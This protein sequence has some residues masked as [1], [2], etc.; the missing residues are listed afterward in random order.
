MHLRNACIGATLV[1]FLIFSPCHAFST[2]AVEAVINGM[3]AAPTPPGLLHNSDRLT[4][5]A[6]DHGSCFGI[7]DVVI[8]T[9]TGQ[10]LSA[11]C[12]NGSWELRHPASE[13]NSRISQ[14]TNSGSIAVR[15]LSNATDVAQGR[16]ISIDP[17]DLIHTIPT[18]RPGDYVTLNSG[19]LSGANIQFPASLGS[20]DGPPITIDASDRVIVNNDT[21]ILVSG[22]NISL[23]HFIFSDVADNAITVTGSK[24]SL[25][26][27]KFTKCGDPQKTQSHCIALTDGASKADI[28]FNEFIGSQ[29]MTI[30][31]RE[32]AVGE[33]QPVNI[34]I[35]YN[36]F[37]DI[38]KLSENG[39]EPI[40]ISGLDGGESS[41]NFA[42][43]IEHNVFYRTNGDRETI[44]LK[45]V[46]VYAR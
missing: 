8:E 41:L 15:D 42:T 32:S 13:L 7:F 1:L 35:R 24:F 19:V 31:V 11:P 44:S 17:Q 4:Q 38:E 18:L 12:S 16:M 46:G 34:L 27:S 36:V 28:A 21:H 39:Q 26:N 23:T 10:S 29:S 22:N 5:E 37:R 9:R 33:H 43:H 3:L 20:S 45:G 30:K 6:N 14:I 2:E 25:T 40:Q